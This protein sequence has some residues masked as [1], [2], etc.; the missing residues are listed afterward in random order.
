MLTNPFLHGKN[1]A[2]DSSSSSTEGG[3][4]GPPAPTGNNPVANVYM[5]KGDTHIMTRDQDYGMPKSTEKGKEI[6]NPSVPLQIEKMMGETMTRIPKCAFKKASHNP[7]ARAAQ[8]YSIVEDLAQTP[9][10]MSSLEV[11]QSFHS[12]RKS[13]LPT[14]GSA[15]TCNPGV[16]ILYP[17]NLKPH[18]SY[19]I[20]FHIVVAYTMKYFTRN[21][22]RTVVD[23]GALT[24]MMSLTCWKAIGQPGLSP[25]PTFLMVFDGHSFRTHGIIPSFPV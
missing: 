13:M 18:L 11:L 9:C 2:Q 23:E 12:Q 21:M 20:A 22:F 16:I 14:L 5:L 8:N 7:N 25:S 24:C 19:H 6:T 4:Q 10:A 3:S 15:E 17:T 1:M